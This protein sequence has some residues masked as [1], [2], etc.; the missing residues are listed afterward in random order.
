M[1]GAVTFAAALP[2]ALGL[3]VVLRSA[4]VSIGMLLVCH[5]AS[6]ALIGLQALD[7]LGGVP[8]SFSTSSL[9]AH[10]FCCSSG[11]P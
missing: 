9:R 2:V 8:A 7:V 10:G 6:V 1:G 3:L 5:G 11:R 4:Q